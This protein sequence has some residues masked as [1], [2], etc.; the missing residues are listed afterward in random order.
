MPID[1]QTKDKPKV[2]SAYIA[3]EVKP[4]IATDMKIS[5]MSD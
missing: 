4:E 5:I 1:P 2:A 3:P